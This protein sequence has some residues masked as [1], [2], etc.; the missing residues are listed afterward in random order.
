MRVLDS[1]LSGKSFARTRLR[2]GKASRKSTC[3][4]RLEVERL[5]DRHLMT[6][7]TTLAGTTLTILGGPGNDRISVLLDQPTNNLVVS[8]S[9]QP[10]FIVPS[11][12]VTTINI[13]SGDGTDFVFVGPGITQDTTITGGT[14]NA[15]FGPG[16]DFFVY[17]GT[18]HGQL[19][20]GNGD[21]KLVG[22]PGNDLL[23]GG[24]GNNILIG[25]SGPGRNVLT[26]GGG[27]NTFYGD[28]KFTIVTNARPTD[29]VLLG[30]GN[31][32]QLLFN[33]PMFGLTASPSLTL[34]ATEVGTLLARASAAT[35]HQDGITAIV[36][37]SGR[38][39]GV[40]VGA[41]VSPTITGNVQNLVFAI[42]GAV[43]E[44]RIAAF[45]GNNQAPLTSRTF[46]DTSQSTITQREADSNPSI[47]DPN[48]TLRGPG[49][50]APIGL[51]DHFPPGVSFTPQV[52]Q[53]QIEHT[54]RDSIYA[55][56]PDNIKGAANGTSVGDDIRLPSRFN[57]NPA[58]IPTSLTNPGVSLFNPLGRSQ[59]LAPPDSYGYESGLLPFAQSRGLG[60]LPGGI[61]IYKRDF[62][63]G[64]PTPGQLIQVGG[65][66]VFFPGKT[67]FADESNSNL[68]TD[69]NANLPDRAFEA[70]YVA[71][72]A[73]GGSNGSGLSI[74]QPLGGVA[75]PV[76]PD[77]QSLF[78][79]PFGRIDLVGITLDVFGPKGL[80]GPD[81]LR[82]EGQM[83]A[84]QGPGVVNGTLEPL[85]DPGQNNIV[86]S[87]PAAGFVP[88][89]IPI[90]TFLAGLLNPT[91]VNPAAAVTPAPLVPAPGVAATDDTGIT[92]LLGGTIAP[93]GFLV[94][95]HASQ[96]GTLSAF[97]V[98]RMIFQGVEQELVTRAAIRLPL[99]SNAAQVFAVT[100]KNGE[101]LG[102]FR[103]PDSTIFSID[104]A[105][106]KA[107]N[108]A[109][110]ANPAAL[111]PIDQLPG[112]PRGV[113]FTAR[114]FRYLG[115]PRFPEGVDNGI[116][117]PFS[118]LNDDR[119]IDKTTRI[120]RDP[121]QI[122]DISVDVTGTGLQVGPPLPADRFVSVVGFDAFNPGTNFR[123]S[124]NNGVFNPANP[125]F[126]D[127]PLLNRD[128]IVFFPGSTATYKNGVLVGGLGDSGDGVDQDDVINTAAFQG[129][130]PPLNLRSDFY[131]FDGIR[132]PFQKF[133]RQPNIN[134]IGSPFLSRNPLL[135]LQNA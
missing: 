51:G 99:D 30:D 71:F 128:G 62:L 76:G 58:F 117:G 44:A 40:N 124:R 81:L 35:P 43:A 45:F 108:A 113:D 127:N 66:G 12:A 22:G 96:D 11:A 84:A 94:A 75:L 91:V 6:A 73:L 61:P 39:L 112:V 92:H 25:G 85:I 37:R 9:G 50:V 15:R 31:T 17:L 1:L 32:G 70:E 135:L 13:N 88:A 47:T 97:D 55:V 49:F 131:F 42:D 106:A 59:G 28:P 2:S 27:I 41:G 24:A 83:L 34:T 118:Q 18:G 79:L 87:V 69:Y 93:E 109:Y 111:Q 130:G 115:L 80:Q 116:A 36:D 46:Q 119:G 64:A 104:V 8:D 132:L 105:V 57:A 101:V 78:D 19:I 20:G 103:T 98:R 72:A 74:K 16:S 56:G 126:F 110:Y 65:I 89:G 107:R 3:R 123:D 52:D 23:L 86:D 121:V 48:S 90:T 5:E 14:P 114:T 53:F 29:R 21:N 129:Y 95:P 100:D 54:N 125:A 82:Q 77:G 122:Q 102:L 68:S 67:G 38:I 134:P 26:G 10:V 60:T 63:P 7:T 4:A 33:D 133:N 120:V